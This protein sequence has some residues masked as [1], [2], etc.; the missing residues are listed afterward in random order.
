MEN[1]M[2]NPSKMPLKQ[3]AGSK[4]NSDAAAF[5]PAASAATVPTAMGGQEN[6]LIDGYGSTGNEHPFLVG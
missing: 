6:Q 1:P 4:M 5:L 3:A 2:E